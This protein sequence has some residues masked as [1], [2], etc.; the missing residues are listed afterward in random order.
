MECEFEKE[1]INSDGSYTRTTCVRKAEVQEGGK[2][3]CF[4]CAYE[5]IKE[6]CNKQQDE[7]EKLRKALENIVNDGFC[8]VNART[9]AEQALKNK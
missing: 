9:W 7:N 5:Y 6:E 1:T 2:L 8:E 4:M 3:L